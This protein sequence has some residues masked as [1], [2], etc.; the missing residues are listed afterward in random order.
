LL[1]PRKGQSVSF[2][3]A[4]VQQRKSRKNNASPR[5][6]A[7]THP[8]IAKVGELRFFPPHALGIL[9]FDDLLATK[10]LP[11][12]TFI[13]SRRSVGDFITRKGVMQRYT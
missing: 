2:E 6:R 3:P 13:L 9:L 11:F 1:D 4:R 8:A 7:I 12:I 10:V 5:K